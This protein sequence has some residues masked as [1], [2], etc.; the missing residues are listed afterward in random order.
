MHRVTDA[1]ILPSLADDRVREQCSDAVALERRWTITA[2]DAG[3]TY[4]FFDS[5]GKFEMTRIDLHLVLAGAQYRSIRMVAESV[6]RAA[7]AFGRRCAA[8]RRNAARTVVPR[9][10]MRSVTQSSCHRTV[11]EASWS[12]NP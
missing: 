9:S 11:V 6:P 4:T 8:F 12:D 2:T 10:A 7:E 3:F 1:A 5:D